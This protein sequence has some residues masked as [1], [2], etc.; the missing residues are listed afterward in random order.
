MQDAYKR[1]QTLIGAKA[2]ACVWKA[3]GKDNQR[4]ERLAALQSLVTSCE[5]ILKTVGADEGGNIIQNEV[6]AAGNDQMKPTDAVKLVERLAKA[7][8]GEVTP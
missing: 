4:V 1:V 6:D 5:T 3:Y 8:N 2:A 7:A